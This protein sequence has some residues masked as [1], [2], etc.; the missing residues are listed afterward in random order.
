MT[1]SRADIEKVAVLAR[2]R[3]DD[4]QIPALEN[5]LSNILSLVDQL[6][7]ANTDN[8]EPLA[9]PL[10]AV[11]RLRADEVTESNQRE[12]FQAIAPVTESGFYLVPRVIE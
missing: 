8:V 4:E 7:A 12:A 6:S 3:L 1:I 10:D 2:I 9:H 11:Q 5:D